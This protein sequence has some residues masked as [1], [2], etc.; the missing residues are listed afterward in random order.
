MAVL[1]PQKA[2]DMG[3]MPIGFWEKSIFFGSIRS[4]SGA[5]IAISIIRGGLKKPPL[6]VG[7]KS[8]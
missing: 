5:K 2:K 1:G 4:L 7:F 3:E 6:M 8:K